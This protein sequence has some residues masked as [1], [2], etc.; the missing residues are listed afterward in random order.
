M[1]DGTVK[2]VTNSTY[3]KP[4]SVLEKNK[5]TELVDNYVKLAQFFGPEVMKKMPV[6]TVLDLMNQAY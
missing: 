5:F 3:N 1:I 6:D 2:I 4:G